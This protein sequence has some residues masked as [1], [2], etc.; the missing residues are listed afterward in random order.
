[1][2][3]GAIP[4]LLPSVPWLNG[5]V[6]LAQVHEKELPNSFE[7]LLNA[8]V[9][10]NFADIARW[11][12]AVRA[13]HVLEGKQELFAAFADIEDRFEPLEQQVNDLVERID[14]ELERE[15]EMQ[16]GK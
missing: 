9:K 16:R 15:I 14:L 12:E 10:Y 11:R 13:M 3:F 8:P 7:E 4:E 1:M 5:V 6:H 2:L